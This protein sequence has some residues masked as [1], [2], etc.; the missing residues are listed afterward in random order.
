MADT[1]TPDAPRLPPATGT[2]GVGNR[3]EFPDWGLGNLIDPFGFLRTISSGGDVGSA[4]PYAKFG[5]APPPAGPF[6]VNPITPEAAQNIEDL[7]AQLGLP[8]TAMDSVRILLQQPNASYEAILGFV[9][10]LGAASTDQSYA[11]Q[12]RADLESFKQLN[13]DTINTLRGNY[14]NR[15]SEY[16]EDPNAPILG[17]RGGFLENDPAY[18]R[19]FADANAAIDADINRAR[20]V[21]SNVNAQTGSRSSGKTS[22]AVRQAQVT[23]GLNKGLIRE[24]LTGEAL[25]EARG[26]RDQLDQLPLLER[27]FASGE[28][29]RILSASDSLRGLQT[30]DYFGPST[31][32]R[33]DQQ[34]LN[35]GRQ[36]TDYAKL[37]Q[38]LSFLSTNINQQTE[39]GTNLVKDLLP[40]SR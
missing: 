2:P 5:P 15:L 27:D 12:V 31:G 17:L 30:P 34:G 40:G 39:Q 16:V 24:N 33:W 37:M 14:T 11:E 10:S 36:D 35:F 7:M 18:S 19:R 25:G 38:A 8:S 23:A 29:P 28:L 22:E 26:I 21:A 9:H 6:G 13:L 1:K 32:L 20:S 4:D 3:P